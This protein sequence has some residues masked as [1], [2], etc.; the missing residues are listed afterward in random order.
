MAKK[1]C[2]LLRFRVCFAYH[3]ASA[4]RE[5]NAFSLPCGR[6]K[7]NVKMIIIDGTKFPS[8]VRTRFRVQCWRDDRS[9]VFRQHRFNDKTFSRLFFPRQSPDEI[10]M[11]NRQQRRWTRKIICLD[12][13]KRLDVTRTRAQFTR[14][15]EF[16]HEPFGRYLYDKTSRF[17]HYKSK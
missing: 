5:N 11:V 7:D 15:N 4:T 9:V 3:D 12:I 8:R 1:Q 14:K 17:Q 10:P 13:S 6:Q 2:Y 16:E